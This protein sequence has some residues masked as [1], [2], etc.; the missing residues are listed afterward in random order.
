MRLRRLAR[1]LA[2][3][4]VLATTAVVVPDA[5][6]APTE[7]ALVKL[8]QGSS[9]DTSPDL[10]WILAVGSDARPGQSMLRSRGDAIQL[11]GMDTRTGRA[12]AIGIPRDSWV[13][14]PGYG[15]Q[16]V[17]AALFFGGA[18]LMGR[19][20]GNLVGIRPDYV[21][22]TRFPF[23]ED[24]IRSIDGIRVTNPRTFSD[25]ELKPGGFPRGTVRLT[26]YEAM[27]F[28]RIRKTLPGG[29][30]ER[31]ANQQRVLRGIH[32]KIRA[33]AHVRGF[34]EAGLL[35]VLKHLYTDL[36]PGELFRLAQAVAAIEPGRITT[37]VV[38]GRIG[39]VGG[40]SVVFP[41]V[42]LAR[43]YGDAARRD[44]EISNC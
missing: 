8:R 5:G 32:A 2:L 27:A 18:E 11:I 9:I 34:M 40:A 39:T 28:A 26:G 30:F 29:D 33:N 6:V 7:V 36:P 3:T 12:T 15:F 43:R 20:V 16:R 24:M 23:F 42:S 31:S 41:D 17:N 35:S 21:F 10:I 37:C 1:T 25:S 13:P 19:T 4:A 38:R 22:V 14:I 44:A